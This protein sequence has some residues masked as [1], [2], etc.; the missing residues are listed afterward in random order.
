MSGFW[1]PSGKAKFQYLRFIGYRHLQLGGVK[2][3]LQ[4][5]KEIRVEL[6]PKKQDNAPETGASVIVLWMFF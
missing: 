4:Q 6:L 5:Q 3:G 1:T 2:N